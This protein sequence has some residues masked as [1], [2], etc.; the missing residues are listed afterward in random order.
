MIT[1]RS[2]RAARRIR[3]A[4]FVVL[5]ALALIVQSFGP[6]AAAE[7]SRADPGVSIIICTANGLKVVPANFAAQDSA[8]APNDF[9][10][11]CAFSL[12]NQCAAAPA[13]AS[14]VEF[15]VFVTDAG[16]HTWRHDDAMAQRAALPLFRP[17]AP[18][19]G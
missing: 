4:T 19:L 17:R 3:R 8:P 10:S 12:C 11:H 13:I 7:I 6:L 2:I 16:F 18:P 9:A 15:N 1:R 14:I 5:A